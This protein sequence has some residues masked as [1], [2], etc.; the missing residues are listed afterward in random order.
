MRST[1]PGGI[2]GRLAVGV[3]E[4][5]EH[6]RPLDHRH[7]VPAIRRTPTSTGGAFALIE[8]GN[9]RGRAIK[10]RRIPIPRCTVYAADVADTVRAAAR[11]GVTRD[12]RRPV[13]RRPDRILRTHRPDLG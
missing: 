6:Y 4:R 12:R 13:A 2:P 8:E 11:F 5:Y 3:V 9:V 10:R 7:R 1:G